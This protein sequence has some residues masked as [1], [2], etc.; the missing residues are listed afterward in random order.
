MVPVLEDDTQ[1]K[2]T[3]GGGGNCT[4]PCK[5]QPESKEDNRLVPGAMRRG[6]AQFHKNIQNSLRSCSVYIT[7]DHTL[8]R[9][10]VKFFKNWIKNFSLTHL[11]RPPTLSAA[12]N[13]VWQNIIN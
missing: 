2:L 1:Q 4:T 8:Q 11:I 12:E 3:D 7:H 5:T 9:S 10:R 13:P 6:L